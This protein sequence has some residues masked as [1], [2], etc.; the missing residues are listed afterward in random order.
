MAKQKWI[1]AV[2]LACSLLASPALAIDLGDD[3]PPLKIKEWVKGD[4]VE[5]AKGKDK[6]IFVIEFW[7]TWC[8]P[9]IEGIPHL[10][11]LQ[12]EYKD[13]GVVLISI[14]DEKTSVVEKFVEKQGGK[15]G[16]VVAV[17]K[18]GATNDA[19]M[20]A[21]GINFIPYSFI[22]DK[23]G[24]LVWQGSPRDID[25]PLK[26]IV[27]GTYDI[28]AA[29]KAAKE[30][31]KAAKK[32]RK[33]MKM[34]AE[35]FEL[36]SKGEKSKKTKKLGKK[37]YKRAKG[38]PPLL[39]EFAWI[40]LT[41]PKLEDHRDLKLARKAARA[42][43]KATEGKNPAI[44]DTYARALFDTG[45]KAE[46]IELQEKAVALAKEPRMK[47]GLEKTLERYKKEAGNEE[48]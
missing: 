19:Y 34:M 29:K 38:D 48:V 35:Y 17:D 24:K 9:C 6:N 31:A 30:A 5:L 18:S 10:T 28:E 14:S 20:K 46:A 37:I 32:A 41:E 44:M 7:A 45:K 21:S 27:E 47:A 23:A 3:A 26:Q 43:N 39:N 16:Y 8:R 33:T 1:P 12:K 15:M 11:E 4:A 36:V 22:V 2:V 25:Q 40:I 13:K 42:A